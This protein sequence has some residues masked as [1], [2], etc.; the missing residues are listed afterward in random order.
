MTSINDLLYCAEK[1][2]N[3]HGTRLTEKRKRVLSVL[4]QS[5]IAL[6]AYE[7]IDVY[8]NEF[9]SSLPAM[10]IYRILDFLQ[11]EH[12]VHKLDLAN[13]YVAC[14][15]IAS[16]HSHTVS[17]FLICKN[18]QKVKEVNISKS[19]ISEFKKNVEGTG[20]NLV[21]QQLEMNCICDNCL[22]NVS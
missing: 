11:K 2:C 5:K 12:L 1:Q 4:L 18:C 20:F 3:L 15:H 17:Q 6:S 19:M 10:S 22:S 14:A 7:L 9:G 16:D 13:K 8:K 21:S